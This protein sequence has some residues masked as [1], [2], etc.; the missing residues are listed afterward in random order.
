MSVRTL[1]IVRNA[2]GLSFGIGLYFY[3]FSDRGEIFLAD[4]RVDFLRPPHA[5]VGIVAENLLQPLPFQFIVINI[6][7][8]SGYS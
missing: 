1:G 5:N 8:N 6:F 3:R 2:A 4:F 7:Y